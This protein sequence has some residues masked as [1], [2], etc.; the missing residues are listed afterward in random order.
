MLSRN[1]RGSLAV[2]WLLGGLLCLALVGGAAASTPTAFAH[3]DVTS[4][5][6][7]APEFPLA[8]LGSAFA[9][10]L[11]KQAQLVRLTLHKPVRSG[12]FSPAERAH[13]ML[14]RPKVSPGSAVLPRRFLLS[15]QTIPR[16]PNDTGDP[17]LAFSSLS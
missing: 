3:G 15:R 14:P 2:R 1:L 13:A 6:L 9:F 7:R 10:R 8:A 12:Q 5:G 16:G 17:L 4:I 11:Q